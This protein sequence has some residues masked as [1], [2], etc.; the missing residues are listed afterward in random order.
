MYLIFYD[1]SSDNVRT[2]VAK[3]LSQMG[4]ERLQFSVYAG[5][6]HPEDSGMWSKIATILQGNQGDKIY[7]LKIS[8][9]SFKRIKIIGTFDIDMNYLC[10]D[11]CSLT[12]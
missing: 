9:E 5:P 3:L 1:I 8:K 6:F 10:G 12:L 2:K 11:S 7:Y 4:Y